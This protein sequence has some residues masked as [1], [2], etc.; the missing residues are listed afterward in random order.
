MTVQ[1]GT[2]V[3]QASSLLDQ[4]DEVLSDHA[5]AAGPS[6]PEPIDRDESV[7]LE[8]GPLD[9][10]DETAPEDLETESRETS[11]SALE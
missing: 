2:R 1:T 6:M 8:P 11:G 4:V 5:T 3:L 10:R 9:D 7:T